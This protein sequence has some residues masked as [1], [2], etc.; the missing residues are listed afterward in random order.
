MS[1]LTHVS[2][3]SLNDFCKC[4]RYYYLGRVKK[5]DGT[6]KPLYFLVGEVSHEFAAILFE[7]VRETGNVD[8]ALQTAR[9]A[10][11][12]ARVKALANPDLTIAYPEDIL[13]QEFSKLFGMME[14]YWNIRKDWLKSIK[15]LPHT[16][17]TFKCTLKDEA[18]VVVGVL[19]AVIQDE[20]GIWIVD[21]KT[22]S[23]FAKSA[24][25]DEISTN[26]QF[27]LYFST[28]ATQMKKK[29]GAPLKGV[30]YDGIEKTAKRLKKN[31]TQKEYRNEM[32][33]E[34]R[35]P[36]KFMFNRIRMGKED[37]VQFYGSFMGKITHLKACF[38][39]LKDGKHEEQ[40]FYRRESSCV[41]FGRCLF[42][43]IC[44]EGGYEA[45]ANLYKM[46][47]DKEC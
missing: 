43:P 1:N 37:M 30:I 39:A 10:L 31:Q 5:L 45:H 3:S 11:E 32:L 18:I 9:R 2:S 6:V 15:I 27:R 36:E 23:S 29:Y 25:I 38:E 17:T 28:Y 35:N 41:E 42:Y 24:N 16:E 19:D 33:E 47:E 34:Y 21:H 22:T 7:T 14:G 4:P 8:R 13:E 46:K 40:A 26:F 12:I 20:D 44:W